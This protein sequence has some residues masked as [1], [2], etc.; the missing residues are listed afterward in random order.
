MLRLQLF[1]GKQK[2]KRLKKTYTNARRL[3]EIVSILVAYQLTEY[4]KVLRLDKS[5]KILQNIVSR[6][7]ALEISKLPEWERIRLALEELGPTFIKFGQL[8]S[9]RTDLLPE[10]LII[11]LV[12]LQDRVPPVSEKG[13]RKVIKREFKKDIDEIFTNFQLKPVASA[14]I[15]QVHRACL[16]DGKKVAV[17]VQRPGIERIIDTDL[18][19]LAALAARIEKYVPDTRFFDP[20][21]LI[22]EFRVQLKIELNFRRELLHLQKFDNILKQFDENKG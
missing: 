11:E 16:P 18:E 15:A 12:K 14:S 22:E 2:K 10:K 13:V 7:K 3:Q 1:P 8:L 4:V 21:G 9:N 5:I 6:K 17:K 20:S 19:I